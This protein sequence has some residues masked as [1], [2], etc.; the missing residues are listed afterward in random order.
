MHRIGRRVRLSHNGVMKTLNIADVNAKL[1]DAE[2][3]ISQARGDLGRGDST[4]ALNRLSNSLAAI[5][6]AM[7]DI[8]G[9]AC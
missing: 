3:S 8:R 9:E 1:A 5:V 4:T 2:A 7:K 6:R